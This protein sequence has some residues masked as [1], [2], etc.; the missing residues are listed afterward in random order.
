MKLPRWLYFLICRLR[1]RKLHTHFYRVR[2]G[3]HTEWVA[4]ET[5]ADSRI[6]FYKCKPFLTGLSSESLLKDFLVQEIQRKET[7]YEQK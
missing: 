1:R 7:N 4:P 6:E 5:W 3:Q 2:K